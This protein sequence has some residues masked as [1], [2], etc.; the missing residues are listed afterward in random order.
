M[1]LRGFHLAGNV[2][3]LLSGLITAP[4]TA[5]ALGPE[6]RGE[7]AIIVVV[8]T[9]LMT[10]AACGIPWLARSELAKDPMSLSFWRRQGRV[11]G[12]ALLP[13]AL[14]CAFLL[15]G[16]VRL[17]P[18]ESISVYVLFVLSVLAAARGIEA[19][20]LITMG[21]PGQFGL[22]NLIGALVT[23]ASITIAFVLGTLSVA[24]VLWTSVA[25]M[26][27]QVVLSVFL[28]HRSMRGHRELLA[29]RERELRA[30]PAYRGRVL[31]AR[32][33]RA[34]GSQAGEAAV[35]RGDTIS[36][37]LIASA[38]QVGYYSIVALIP[39]AA[40]AVY[41]TIVQAS[42]SRDRGH[43]LD[44]FRHV[45]QTCVAVS[46]AGVLVGGPAAWLLI[47]LVFGHDFTTSREYLPAG[48]VMTL[49]LATI[50]PV[51][52]RLSA[53]RKPLLPLVGILIAGAGGTVAASFVVA[54]SLVIVVLGA[55]LWLGGVM[56]AAFVTQGGA[57]R[58]KPRELLS[59]WRGGNSAAK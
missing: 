15:I 37:S 28:V 22:A 19:N 44:Q 58:P 13:I 21:K 10:V 36:L 11:V 51:I 12:L 42:Y 9:V 39:Q 31:L 17:T 5:R 33:S 52:Q 3:P 38:S 30:D 2:A 56:Y 34:W 47:P 4:L 25:S 49:A 24:T 16:A 55:L 7:V 23:L 6:G 59:W 45:F 41:T 8:A 46:V 29:Q 53:G 57:L 27:T 43:E 48:L 35:T 50:A 32:G 20:A 14:V 18:L 1:A 54:P 26:G 40:Y